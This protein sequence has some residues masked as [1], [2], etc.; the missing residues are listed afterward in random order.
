MK[1]R[2]LHILFWSVISAAFI[3]PGT[4]TTAASAGAGYGYSLIWALI[5]STVACYVLQE[6]SA[7]I[8]AASGQNLG[9]AMRQQY[10]RSI[11]GKELIWLS[12]A[13]ILSGCIAFEAGNI[14]GTV[15]G[16]GVIT[17]TIPVPVIV[18]AI[19]LIAAALLWSGTVKQ[20]ATLLGLIVAVMGACFVITAFLIPHDIGLLFKS[21]F[22]P[23]IPAGAEILVMGLIGTT[24][25]PYNI[26]LGSGLRHTQT[27]SEMKISLLIAI[28][29]GGVVSIAILLTG[30]AISGEFTFAELADALSERIGHW[31]H[32]L[33]GIGLFGAG[34][35]STLTAAL[36]ASVT[37][38]SLLAKSGSDQNWTEKGFRF[39]LVWIIVLGTGLI[40]GLAGLKPEPAIILAQ[41]L[42]GIILPVIAVVLFLLMNSRN[43]LSQK[44][45]NGK[46][47]N[48]LMAIVV[49]LTVLIGITNVLRAASGIFS[50]ILPAQGTITILSLVIFLIIMGLAGSGSGLFQSKTN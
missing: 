44:F 46:A 40:F 35:S 17:D 27:V 34:I 3:G 10:N 13:A 15:A 50:F 7:R 24:V 21:G 12:L 47:Y 25:V 18:T 29:L 19:G 41:A 2:V 26:F 45:R 23:E 22:K 14:L 49:Y 6:A 43:V 11:L 37:A 39:R 28:G 42:N 9:E 16:V 5:F 4:V 36:A 8:T 32:L 20:I 38:K 48:M 1:K 33:L 30:T 31:G